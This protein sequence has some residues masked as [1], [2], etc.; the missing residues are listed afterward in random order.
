MDNLQEK[1]NKIGYKPKMIDTRS[2]GEKVDEF[3]NPILTPYIN[4]RPDTGR[5]QYVPED[6]P[7][8][9]EDYSN[10]INLIKDIASRTDISQQTK[11]D[12]INK[13]AQRAKKQ[14][15]QILSISAQ[16]YENFSTYMTKRAGLAAQDLIMA[17]QRIGTA[18][19]EAIGSFGES[20]ITGKPYEEILAKNKKNRNELLYLSVPQIEQVLTKYGKGENLIKPSKNIQEFLANTNNMLRRERESQYEMGAN[21]GEAKDVIIQALMGSDYGKIE[22]PKEFETVA[23]ITGFLFD[24]IV[25]PSNLLPGVGIGVSGTKAV[26]RKALRSAISN[27]ENMED[28]ITAAQKAV[29]NGVDKK[30][31][32]KL[33]YTR[34]KDV[35]K[36]EVAPDLVEGKPLPQ[37]RDIASLEQIV[38]IYEGMPYRSQNYDELLKQRSQEIL[39]EKS[40]EPIA[41]KMAEEKRIEDEMEQMWQA[42]EALNKKI[43]EALKKEYT[44]EK[45]IDSQ[46]AEYYAN[47]IPIESIAYD[48][49]SRNIQGMGINSPIN[50]TAMGELIVQMRELGLKPEQIDINDIR[51]IYDRISSLPT[52]S[53]ESIAKAIEE[54]K[55]VI[56]EKPAFSDEIIKKTPKDFNAREM[57]VAKIPTTAGERNMVG[58]ISDEGVF[59]PILSADREFYRSHRRK[60]GIKEIKWES[61]GKKFDLESARLWEYSQEEFFD[62][63]GGLPFKVDRRKIIKDALIAGEDVPN[64][65][66]EDF[67]SLAREYGYTVEG[68]PNDYY[69]YEKTTKNGNK[70]LI[71]GDPEKAAETAKDLGIKYKKG[72][73]GII[74]DSEDAD[75]F[76]RETKIKIKKPASVSV[77]E[78]QVGTITPTTPEKP[79]EAQ[80][81]GQAGQGVEGS[82]NNFMRLAKE[83]AKTDDTALFGTKVKIKNRY[84]EEFDGIVVKTNS[85]GD[86]ITF[87][88]SIPSLGH[89]FPE[90]SKVNANEIVNI[91]ELSFKPKKAEE[92]I[93][94]PQI[95]KKTIEE[96]KT[97]IEAYQQKKWGILASHYKSLGLNSKEFFDQIAK[98]TVSTK[99]G[100]PFDAW[101]SAKIFEQAQKS[102][103]FI[104]KEFDKATTS[105][106]THINN[107]G[108]KIEVISDNGKVVKFIDEK[109]GTG[110]YPKS[111][112]ESSYKPIKSPTE[113]LLEAPPAEKN[114][115]EGVLNKDGLVELN[116][117]FNPLKPIQEAYQPV[118]KPFVK[119]TETVDAVIRTMD[120]I[121]GGKVSQFVNKAFHGDTYREVRKELQVAGQMAHQDIAGVSDYVASTMTGKLNNDLTDWFA[122]TRRAWSG[123]NADLAKQFKTIMETLGD[124]AEIKQGTGVSTKEYTLLNYAGRREEKMVE[125]A[126]A[127]KGRRRVIPE[128]EAALNNIGIDSVAFSTLKK[129]GFIDKY[130]LKSGGKGVALTQVGKQVAD[131]MIKYSGKT[132]EELAKFMKKVDRFVA[133][134]NKG[135]VITLTP[136]VVDSIKKLPNLV[137]VSPM[138][139]G[140]DV[141][142]IAKYA[143]DEKGI[144]RK[145]Q[146]YSDDEIKR[147]V[148]D[149]YLHEYF[150]ERGEQ[151]YR[152]TDKGKAVRNEINQASFKDLAIYSDK[153]AFADVLKKAGINAD[154]DTEEI[155]HF[156]VKWFQENTVNLAE[157]IPMSEKQLQKMKYQ[158]GKYFPKQ[159]A[160]LSETGL[161]KIMDNPEIYTKEQVELATDIHNSIKNPK[162]LGVK[163]VEYRKNLADAI[164]RNVDLSDDGVKV[165]RQWQAE[166]GLPYNPDL[167]IAADAKDLVETQYLRSWA[168][169]RSNKEFSDL[170][171]AGRVGVKNVDLT[172]TMS[173]VMSKKYDAMLPYISN[174][175]DV[176]QG[177]MSKVTNTLRMNDAF[178]NLAKHTEYVRTDLDPKYHGT[179]YTD[180]VD[181]VG[182]TYKYIN[183]EQTE[184]LSLAGKYVNENVLRSIQ[185][186]I[187]GSAQSLSKFSLDG[188][189]SKFLRPI[190]YA[191]MTSSNL[192]YHA[193]N[194]VTSGVNM[195]LHA[196]QLGLR[197]FSVAKTSLKW[198]K[199]FG[200]PKLRREFADEI[201]DMIEHQI[202]GQENIAVNPKSYGTITRGNIGAFEIN[203]TIN[204]VGVTIQE[205]LNMAP[206]FAN[207]SDQLARIT[208]YQEKINDLKKIMQKADYKALSPEQQA[209]FVAQFKAKAADQAQ[210]IIPSYI[211]TAN[212]LRAVNEVMPLVSWGIKAY[213]I[214]YRNL[215]TLLGKNDIKGFGNLSKS[216]NMTEKA[217]AAFALI[218]I[219]ALAGYYAYNKVQTNKEQAMAEAATTPEYRN[220]FYDQKWCKMIPSIEDLFE[221]QED[222]LAAKYVIDA[223]FNRSFSFETKEGIVKISGS[224][225]GERYRL[226]EFSSPLVTYGNII[227]SGTKVNPFTGT[228]EPIT[229][230]EGWE[231]AKDLLAY[232]IFVSSANSQ[233][234][235]SEVRRLKKKGLDDKQARRQAYAKLVDAETLLRYD[236]ITQ[237]DLVKRARGEQYRLKKQIAGL[238][239][240]TPEE[241]EKAIPGI[242]KQGERVRVRADLIDYLPKGK[243]E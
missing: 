86:G 229:D 203:K 25:D 60:Y 117:G 49:I 116:A 108:L 83:T 243:E 12:Q 101:E 205:I 78:E 240:M 218:G 63:E 73:I 88:I 214:P 15:A 143:P 127:V 182:V 62:I 26:S 37:A 27:A 9:E 130:T 46:R 84:G 236:V 64:N 14:Q 45:D 57:V 191:G 211:D 102:P 223:V 85:T 141:R 104:L 16:P 184:Y 69:Q 51:K 100:L 87:E 61:M 121:A 197:P 152:L 177:V 7:P 126:G 90:S 169:N 99:D 54:A 23:G 159:R 36:F 188:T 50:P 202:I 139:I 10:T 208:Y 70:I 220:N 231:R 206:A 66:L 213:K 162:V 221:R 92:E 58:I 179:S 154:K 192:S 21:I 39:R 31:A 132:P 8:L 65:V 175:T 81:S 166:A 32:E 142:K 144:L 151:V 155:A 19:G 133:K 134:V 242:E 209:D 1:F 235:N 186:R 149:G 239:K 41:K 30:E 43:E 24:A 217:K 226:P 68:V 120:N 35:K 71:S 106:F 94:Q 20:V 136:D 241:Q 158:W 228:G 47:K 77:P 137:D 225:Y 44:G 216:I 156:F 40:Q 200:S 161:R 67:P 170:L 103:S 72:E 219:P 113:Q 138:N 234:Y 79:P 150:N 112:F 97:L 146:E 105:K 118:I 178:E 95:I 82:V 174:P 233:R 165:P 131:E 238:K 29:V 98:N 237:E 109:G 52:I 176:L 180:V 96:P 48:R 2:F 125:K 17:P 232:T 119:T 114:F 89:K 207:M 153:K 224:N 140:I 194:M 157:K 163:V 76:K 34:L 93:T 212:A 189:W 222:Y 187:D 148:D 190:W 123:L 193:I 204:K 128:N 171:Q 147:L 173:R 145:A 80:I 74:V 59:K 160:T 201:Q 111:F 185:T 55:M 6:I 107:N 198:F 42:D 18:A 168:F 135:Q 3:F 129:L 210:T 91:N 215:M 167:K 11:S 5:P 227:F 56:P 53:K 38:D 75:I 164:Q 122:N 196:P 110:S 22:T 4:A 115:Y 230:K 181:G 172:N 195:L 33:F 199:T 124:F 183:P 13:L 28:L